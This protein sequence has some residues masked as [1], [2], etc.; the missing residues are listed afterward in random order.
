M[1]LERDQVKVLKDHIWKSLLIFCWVVSNF[2][3]Q[4]GENVATKLYFLSLASI[5]ILIT[6]KIRNNHWFNYTIWELSIYNFIEEIFNTADKYSPYEIPII[7]LVL[8]TANIKL[9]TKMG[10]FLLSLKATL[11]LKFVLFLLIGW[12]YKYNY[13]NYSMHLEHHTHTIQEMIYDNAEYISGGLTYILSMV[14]LN[15]HL[16]TYSSAILVK[17]LSG[18]I[19]LGFTLVVVIATHF[20]KKYLDN[21]YGNK[22]D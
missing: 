3:E 1:L 11:I 7:L 6:Y 13:H 8:I 18:M 17:L 20:L 4:I 12:I 15:I 22:K 9:K 14:S 5:F 10:E 19:S 21:K 16:S 2:Q